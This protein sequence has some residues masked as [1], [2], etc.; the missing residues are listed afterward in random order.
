LQAE[1]VEVVHLDE[2]FDQNTKD[3]VWIE[4][5]AAEQNWAIVTQDRIRKNELEREAL[6]STGILTFILSKDWAHQPEWNKA[7][8]LV[9]WWPTL[10]R[11]GESVSRGAYSV[12]FK[13]SGKGKVDPVRI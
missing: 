2:K 12:P 7:A 13:L 10:M 8:A 4:A 5:L 3:H 9:R 11:L 6:R 1:G